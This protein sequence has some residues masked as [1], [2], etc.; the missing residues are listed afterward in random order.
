MPF[1]VCVQLLKVLVVV[2]FSFLSTNMGNKLMKGSQ[3]LS[4][5]DSFGTNFWIEMIA[6]WFHHQTSELCVIY[7]KLVKDS[8]FYISPPIMD[9]YF[10]KNK[11]TKKISHHRGLFDDTSKHSCMK[12]LWKITSTFVYICNLSYE[13]LKLCIFQLVHW[14]LETKSVTCIFLIN[15]FPVC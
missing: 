10:L 3:P 5:Y 15:L 8:Y 1:T 11:I 13:N 4:G 9:F 7:L 12:L 6:H 2:C 14:I